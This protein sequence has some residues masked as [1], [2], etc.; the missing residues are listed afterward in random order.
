MN[1]LPNIKEVQK[2]LLEMGIAIRDILE[3]HNIPYFIAYG[4]LLGAIRHNGFIPWDD[5][6]DFYLFEE[7]YDSAIEALRTELPTSMLVEDSHSE[8][9]FFHGWARIKCLNTIAENTLF[10]QDSIY[11]HHG[12]NVDLFK[13]Y[14]IKQAEEPAL[15]YREYV[16]YLDRRKKHQLISDKDYADRMKAAKQRYDS[17]LERNDMVDNRFVYAFPSPYDDRIFPE[18]LFPLKRYHFEGHEFFGPNN[19]DPFLT[20][21]YGEYMKLPSK[22]KR[23]SHYSKVEFIK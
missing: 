20:R 15:L 9:F 19:A 1:S 17:M 5:D 13:A 4:T 10:P 12:I 3:S 2:R 18:E 6:F 16:N 14:K 22:E 21:C 11:S 23:A 8:P 7:S